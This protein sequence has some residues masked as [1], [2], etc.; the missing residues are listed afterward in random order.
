MT[1]YSK[2]RLP[3][4]AELPALEPQILLLCRNVGKDIQKLRLSEQTD[5]A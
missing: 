2:R 5:A 1:L 4:P 3:Y